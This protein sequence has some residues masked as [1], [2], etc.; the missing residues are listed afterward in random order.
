MDRLVGELEEG[1]KGGF[2][3]Q[4]DVAVLV[5]GGF[6][7]LGEG[8]VLDRWDDASGGGSGEECRDGDGVGEHDVGS[9]CGR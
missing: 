3:G 8:V 7:P 1:T 5:P 2:T 9:L 6:A 4:F